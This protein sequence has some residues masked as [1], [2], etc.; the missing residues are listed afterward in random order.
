M[1]LG[2]NS[3]QRYEEYIYEKVKDLPIE[4]VSKNEGISPEKIEI[5]FQRM[6]RIKKKTGEIPNV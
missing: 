3:T 2:R 1:E 6:S 4:Q 5:I